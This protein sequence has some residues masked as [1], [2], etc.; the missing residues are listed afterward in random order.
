MKE[1]AGICI[2]ISTVH[3]D[4]SHSVAD[5]VRADVANLV[6]IHPQLVPGSLI[7]RSIGGQCGGIG[8]PGYRTVADAGATGIPEPWLTDVELAEER[9]SAATGGAAV[10]APVV[11]DRTRSDSRQMPP[12]PTLIGVE[13]RR[14]GTLAWIM[15]A[16]ET[17]AV[18]IVVAD[19]ARMGRLLSH[20]RLPSWTRRIG[21]AATRRP[22]LVVFEWSPVE[23]TRET[24]RQ[25]VGRLLEVGHSPREFDRVVA[26]GRPGVPG[27]V[28]PLFP[29]SI[30]PG[31]TAQ[32]LELS[33]R[34]IAPGLAS[35][36]E[37]M[38][39]GSP[40]LSTPPEDERTPP[41]YELGA[42]MFGHVTLDGTDFRLHFEAGRLVG[43]TTAGQEA[44]AVD[45]RASS[46]RSCTYVQSGPSRFT[47]QTAGALS[48][49]GDSTRGLRTY[50]TLRGHRWHMSG[51]ATIDY[52]VR[53]DSPWVFVD[54][55]VTYPWFAQAMEVDAAEMVE[56]PLTTAPLSAAMP[57]VTR[58]Q[59]TETSELVRDV[60]EWF[61]GP[62]A[63]VRHG[64]ITT[65]IA[66]VDDA[67]LATLPI[68]LVVRAKPEQ[69]GKPEQETVLVLRTGIGYR[70]LQSSH[71]QGTSE[72]HTYAIHVTTDGTAEVPLPPPWR[73]P[74]WIQRV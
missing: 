46:I 34:R 26:G 39:L 13:P 25:F 48:I 7:V 19:K 14:E 2:C 32:L 56:L 35:S 43:T 67:G 47:Y 42:D 37:P 68:R 70:N 62:L 64:G 5:D 15:T 11:F 12:V 72:H 51:R 52:V 60:E 44:E 57:T 74:P 18:G 16:R 38:R 53:E 23:E 36:W 71:L 55:Y 29:P 24:L 50:S 45:G 69:K 65:R 63:V 66:R 30:G 73:T 6:S 41:T 54:I 4:E 27:C 61:P 33:R 31:H 22:F 3:L 59:S 40:L 9:A 17:V 28:Q 20:S 21:G 58:H 49:E 8:H 10:Y 1:R